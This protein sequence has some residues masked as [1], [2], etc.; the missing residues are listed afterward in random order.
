MH[1]WR[2]SNIKFQLIISGIHENSWETLV[3]NKTKKE[4]DDDQ[5][6]KLMMSE[7]SD[8]NKK[9]PTRCMMNFGKRPKDKKSTRITLRYI[10]REAVHTI[11]VVYAAFLLDHK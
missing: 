8:K 11:G 7:N 6:L 1:S 3:N 4:S 5:N 2:L 10:S 9:G